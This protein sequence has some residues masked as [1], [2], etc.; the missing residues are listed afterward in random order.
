MSGFFISLGAAAAWG[1]ADFY[2]ATE[3]RR[4]NAFS[5]LSITQPLGLLLSLLLVAVIGGGDF[6]LDHLGWATLA[7]FVGLGGIAFYFM[8]MATGTISVVAPVATLGVIVPV[9][10]G[11]VNGE[12]PSTMTSIGIVIGI[13]AIVF[14]SYEED[15]EHKQGARRGLIYG[16]LAGLGFG[17]FFV[18]FDLAEPREP[19]WEI[20][21]S[22]L[23]GTLA[24]ALVLL[25][26]RTRPRPLRESAKWLV[27]IAAMDVLAN[28]LFGLA[29]TQGALPVVSVGASMYPIFV[30][31][32]AHVTLG[33]RL[34]RLQMFGGILALGGSALI[35]L[36]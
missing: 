30:I 5:V 6:Q 15:P 2:G 19:G 23:G 10:F 8:G 16:V 1:V 9:I 34:H 33:E 17:L 11:V 20:V 26:T 21:G 14:L 24:I 7:G 12:A 27:L 13:G 32:L 36:G 22:R 18:F 4:S 35:V 25:L 28:G 31:A 3:T 29:T